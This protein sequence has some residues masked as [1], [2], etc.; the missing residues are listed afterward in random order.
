M[1]AKFIKREYIIEEFNGFINGEVKIFGIID[2]YW[3][4][5]ESETE[6]K[7]FINRDFLILFL[8]VKEKEYIFNI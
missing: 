3:A 7:L 1:R 8:R 2:R 4:Y 5:I 6:E